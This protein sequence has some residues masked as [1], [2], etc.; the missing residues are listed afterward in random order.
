[1]AGMRHLDIAGEIVTTGIAH[2]IV[3]AGKLDG[4]IP[5]SF[6]SGIV[7]NDMIIPMLARMN[8]G[9]LILVIAVIVVA[10]IITVVII[11]SDKK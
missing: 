5:V 8:G 4:G 7:A 10:F 3:S 6:H 1:M 9:G 11:D 2:G